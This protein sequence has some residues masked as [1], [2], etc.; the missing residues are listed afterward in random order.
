MIWDILGFILAGVIGLAALF[1][2]L[3]RHLKDGV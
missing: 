1:I 3:A 2:W